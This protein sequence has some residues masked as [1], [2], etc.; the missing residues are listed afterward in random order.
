MRA[1]WAP[2]SP[3]SHAGDEFGICGERGIGGDEARRLLE[4]LRNEQAI[5]GIAMDRRK[6]LHAKRRDGS[7]REFFEAA[8]EGGFEDVAGRDQ[9]VRLAER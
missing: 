9:K 6:V 2:A 8:R 1:T 3:R 7:D 5:E 4:R